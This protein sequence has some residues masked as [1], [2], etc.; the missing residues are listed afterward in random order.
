LTKSKGGKEPG[1]EEV[2]VAVALQEGDAL[3]GLCGEGGH[4][5]V[6]RLKPTRWYS[7]LPFPERKTKKITKEINQFGFRKT[8]SKL[9]VV[10][11]FHHKSI[12]TLAH[13]QS[14]Q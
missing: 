9:F 11:Q 13:Q 6:L 12:T 1:G 8:T 3:Q 2:S 4:L 14:V 7:R 10:L 5:I